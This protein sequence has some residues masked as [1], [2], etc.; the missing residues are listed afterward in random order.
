[1]L[2]ILSITKNSVVK[3]QNPVLNHE[4]Q[5]VKPNPA[6]KYLFLLSFVL[7]V[8]INFLEQSFTTFSKNGFS[9]TTLADEMLLGNFYVEKEQGLSPMLTPCFLARKCWF[10][11]LYNIVSVID[12][13]FWLT[14]GL[15]PGFKCN[16]PFYANALF[17]GVWWHATVVCNMHF[18]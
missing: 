13:L 6:T 10:C 18:L 15:P 8:N 17:L 7:D 11:Q 3:I 9:C 14:I 12:I 5:P 4:S 2:F 16:F 1:M